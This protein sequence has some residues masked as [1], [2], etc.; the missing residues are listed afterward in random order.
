MTSEV[1]TAAARTITV[2]YGA[3]LPGIQIKCILL[4]HTPY[5]AAEFVDDSF[6]LLL[7]LIER[8]PRPSR[9]DLNVGHW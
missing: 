1:N 5:L 2:K 9:F 4:T 8:S 3:K 6:M 7:L